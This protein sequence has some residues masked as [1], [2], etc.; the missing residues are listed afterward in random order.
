MVNFSHTCK[1]LWIKR[2]LNALNVKRNSELLRQA[3]LKLDCDNLPGLVTGTPLFGHASWS[4]D[5]PIFG[6]ASQSCDLVT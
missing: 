5:L 2:L 3:L 1:L 4:C 6:N